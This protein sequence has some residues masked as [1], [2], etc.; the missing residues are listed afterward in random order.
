MFD[1]TSLT[2]L[3]CPYKQFD[4][5]HPGD[6]GTMK[7][8]SNHKTGTSSIPKQVQALPEYWANKKQKRQ[9]RER[10]RVRQWAVTWLSA[11][12]DRAAARNVF[13]DSEESVTLS[14]YQTLCDDIY[15]DWC[16]R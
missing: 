8:A 1:P 10:E 9:V 12:L 7:H 2:S 3:D 5:K 4:A 15:K 13:Y 6:K 11:H 16:Q 14:D